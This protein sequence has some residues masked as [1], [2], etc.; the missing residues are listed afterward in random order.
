MNLFQEFVASEKNVIEGE[1]QQVIA[2]IVSLAAR[3]INDSFSPEGLLDQVKG[4][5]RK[6]IVKA[7]SPFL[8]LQCFP[9]LQACPLV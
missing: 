6:E 2:N 3:N 5:Y 4:I 9:Q 7:I 8:M 1:Y